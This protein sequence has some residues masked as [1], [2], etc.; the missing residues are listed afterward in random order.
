MNWIFF[1][2]FVVRLFIQ[3]VF[4]HSQKLSF[5]FA[6]P[7]LWG[8]VSVWILTSYKEPPHRKGFQKPKLSA[9]QHF[10]MVAFQLKTFSVSQ[11]PEKYCFYFKKWPYLA[12]V[13][14]GLSPLCRVGFVPS[15]RKST[16]PWTKG[17]EMGWESPWC[18][19]GRLFSMTLDSVELP[20]LIKRC[21]LLPRVC[22][23]LVRQDV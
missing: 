7:L 5:S 20:P 23:V 15:S 21:L 11:L 16:K 4:S 2:W 14:A 10:T 17:A 3:P 22:S 1:D 12:A 13:T 9:L 8:N 6:F 19:I 18:K